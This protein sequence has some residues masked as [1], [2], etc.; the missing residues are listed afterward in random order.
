LDDEYSG[1][2]KLDA[3]L[4]KRLLSAPSFDLREPYGKKNV[5]LRRIATLCATSN[6]TELLNDPTGNRRNIIFE[7]TGKFSYD[8]YNAINKA[9]LFA[10]IVKMHKDGYKAEIT[11]G[12]IALIE[13]YTGEKHAETSIESECVAML[14]EEPKNASNYD[15]MT[16]TKIKDI[17]EKNTEQKLSIKKLGMELKRMGYMRIRKNNIYGYQILP[18]FNDSK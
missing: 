14:F 6:E 13:Q 17:I 15:F 16:A 10:Q 8:K 18:K 11:D 2:S 7:V 12:M 5:T 3:K 4:I 1:K 9:Q